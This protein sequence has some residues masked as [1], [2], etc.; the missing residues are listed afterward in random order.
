MK[1]T[2]ERPRCKNCEIYEQE[3]VFT[4]NTRR[5]RPTNA[6]LNE[7]LEENRRLREQVSEPPHCDAHS[8]TH[9]GTGD[10]SVEARGQTQHQDEGR[11][12]ETHNQQRQ[13]EDR[14]VRAYSPAQ[15]QIEDQSETV[16]QTTY[17]EVRTNTAHAEPIHEG[18]VPVE[19]PVS[20]GSTTYHGPTSTLFNE[21]SGSSRQSKSYLTKERETWYVSVATLWATSHR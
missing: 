20:V 14:R 16:D 21:A 12:A 10:Q 1:C 17:P 6:A 5:P 8:Q 13:V 7:L 11:F 15:C 3:C 2:G 9:N 4:E 18:N 19:T